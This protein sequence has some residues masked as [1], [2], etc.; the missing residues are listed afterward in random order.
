VSRDIP[1]TTYFQAIT[2]EPKYVTGPGEYEIAG[3]LM[4][5]ARTETGADAPE[6]A[7]RNTAY[8][9]DID[10]VRVCHLGAIGRRP[11]SEVVE[12]LSGA[13]VLLVPVGGGN[14]LNAEAAAET[15]S[16]MEPKIVI[17]MLFKTDAAT[18]DLE[19][20]DKFLKEMGAEGK[21]PESRLTVTKSTLPQDTTVVL[22]NY[23]G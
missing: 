16:L 7:L 5:G 22:L 19:S 3:V 1:D 4:A 17:P 12:A 13:D 8:I 10:D 15:V 6:R 18:A 21:T 14:V 9:F 23:R 11:A 2:N 20:V